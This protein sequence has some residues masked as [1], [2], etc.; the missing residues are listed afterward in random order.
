MCRIQTA[1]WSQTSSSGL[2]C[3]LRD[4][5]SVTSIPCCARK[6][7]VSRLVL[8]VALPW[9]YTKF[10]PNTP[11]LEGHDYHPWLGCTRLSVSPLACSAHKHDNHFETAWSKA[12]HWR[13]I[14]SSA[15][16]PTFC[17]FS[18]A[19]GGVPVIQPVVQPVTPGRKPR[20]KT[21]SQGPVYNVWNWQ[22]LRRI[23]FTHRQGAEMKRVSLSIRIS[24]CLFGMWSDFS[25]NHTSADVDSQ[26]LCWCTLA[27][28]STSLLMKKHTHYWT[29][30]LL[31]I[32]HPKQQQLTKPGPGISHLTLFRVA[33]H[34]S[35]CMQFQLVVIIMRS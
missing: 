16:G 20:L 1:I 30:N 31:G 29:V 35:N 26:C 32:L 9:T 2:M 3:G 23:I 28:Y 19:D 22:S 6:A 34:I 11:C 12:H 33:G 27:T 18:P 25:D 8:V 5:Q 13:H 21:S 15:L 10:L 17:A 7:V 4:G 14:A 24:F